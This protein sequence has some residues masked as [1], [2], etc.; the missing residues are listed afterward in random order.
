MVLTRKRETLYRKTI[1][2]F[3]R[4]HQ[5]LKAIEELL[6]L[7][8]ELIKLLVGKGDRNHIIEEMVDV[9]IILE[10]L[11]IM[12]NVNKEQIAKFRKFK[13]DRL[14]KYIEEKENDKQGNTDRKIDKAPRVEKDTNK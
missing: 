2:T 3:G 8:I 6:E 9:M 10:E 1:Q 12:F 4:V 14:G 5:I 7:A 13:L 11:L